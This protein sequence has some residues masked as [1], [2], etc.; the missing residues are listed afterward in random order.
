MSAERSRLC[1]LGYRRVPYLRAQG[2]YGYRCRAEPVEVDRRTGGG[3]PD[4]VGRACRCNALLANVGLGQIR[5][6]G[7]AEPPWVTL[8]S[9]LHGARELL[10]RL[11]DGWS[12]G[13]ALAWL[14]GAG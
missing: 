12:A 10:E 7:Y 4:A 11:P 8:G 3:E 1:D 13:E 6:D 9:D 14:R 2:G 5:H